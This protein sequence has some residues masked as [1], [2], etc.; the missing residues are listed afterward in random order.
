MSEDLEGKLGGWADQA[1]P[2]TADEARARAEAGRF[3]AL[4]PDGASGGGPAGPRRLMA[5]AAAV[6]LVGAVAVGGWILANDGDESPTGV[7]TLDQPTTTNATDPSTT[8]VPTTAPGPTTVPE[9]AV[10]EAPNLIVVHSADHKLEVIDRTTGSTVRVLAEFDDPE[11]EVSDGEGALMGRY[12]G[13]F[14]VSPDGQTVFYETCCEP[15]VGEVFRIPITGGE[16]EMVTYGTNP[17]VSPDGSRLA[18]IS[19]APTALPDDTVI[20]RPAL[21]VVDL[22]DGSEQRYPLAEDVTLLANPAWSPDGTQLALERYD[23]SAEDGRVML[24]TF[25]GAQDVLQAAST[26]AGTSVEG[27]PMHP[28]FDADGNVVVIRQVSGIDL[29]KGSQAETYRA[30]GELDP[31]AVVDLD[32]TVLFQRT[33]GGGRYVL[34]MFA[35]GMLS[36]DLGDGKTLGIIGHGYLGAAW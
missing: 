3:G 31:I 24:V 36:G 29:T 21:K 8:V 18:V 34:R 4:D 5:A 6:V 32:G 10:S 26:V 17:A 25:D 27:I 12:L 19:T 11:A 20:D 22:T 30:S 23:D 33:A 28:V 2:V 15:A 13:P 7:D 35:D 9:V 16:P 1:S 14:V